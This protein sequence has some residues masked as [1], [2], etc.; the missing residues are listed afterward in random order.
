MVFE[1]A[2]STDDGSH[3]LRALYNDRVLP[4]G[5][6]GG[7]GGGGGWVALAEFRDLLAPYLFESVEEYAA[8]SV[9][10]GTIAMPGDTQM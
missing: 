7:G 10:H 8:A 4:I 3:F 9:A 5:G 6:G 2:T 1:R